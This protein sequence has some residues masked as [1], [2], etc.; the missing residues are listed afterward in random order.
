MEVLLD[1]IRTSL[2]SLP[3]D[4]VVYPGHGPQTTIADERATNPFLIA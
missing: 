3:D 4:F 1:S 2:L